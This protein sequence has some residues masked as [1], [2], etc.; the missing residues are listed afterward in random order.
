MSGDSN[1]NR[2]WQRELNKPDPTIDYL[3]GAYFKYNDIGSM[4]VKGCNKGIL[5]KL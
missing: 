1:E 3:Q 4:D 2:D 5:C